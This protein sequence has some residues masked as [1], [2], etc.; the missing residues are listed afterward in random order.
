M[1]VTVDVA[2][3][4]TETVSVGPEATYA[5]LLDPLGLNPHEV[6]VLVEDQSVPLDQ[7]IETD[8]VR[9]LRLIKGG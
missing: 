2:G 6:S 3:A 4:A 1:E 5:A 9:V 8:H 7:P